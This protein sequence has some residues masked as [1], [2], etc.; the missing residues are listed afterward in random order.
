MSFKLNDYNAFL[1]SLYEKKPNIKSEQQWSDEFPVDFDFRLAMST[2][3]TQDQFNNIN[4]EF[5]AE[6]V[7]LV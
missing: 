5:I 3:N 4:T 1:T 2:E 7:L 6:Q